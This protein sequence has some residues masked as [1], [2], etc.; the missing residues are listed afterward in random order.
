MKSALHKE[1]EEKLS[2]TEDCFV[3]ITCKKQMIDGTMSIEMSYGG[4]DPVLA[5]YLLANAQAYIS[6]E[7][8]EID[9]S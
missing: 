7:V 3:L 4:D 9:E 1:L 2:E 5:S 6:E 8:E